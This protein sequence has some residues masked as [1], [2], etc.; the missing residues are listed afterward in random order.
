MLTNIQGGASLGNMPQF[1]QYY[2]GGW[3][4]VR[5][6][7]SFTDLG[8]GTSMLMATAEM[9]TKLPFVGGL[10]N[11]IAKAID[12]NVKGVFFIDAGQVGGNS[13]TNTLLTRSYLGAAV[14]LGLRIKVPMLGIV[15]LD[16][17]FPLISSA[18]GAILH[19]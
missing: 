14:G 8:T 13:V 11:K 17:G 4:G 16:Y 12:R 19:A 7:R 10:D 3:N 18:L 6:Y 5:G 9:R 15:R 1:A 2:M